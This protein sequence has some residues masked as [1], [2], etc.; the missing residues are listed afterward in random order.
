MPMNI[1]SF[2][3]RRVWLTRALAC[4]GGTA[5]LPRPSSAAV[6]DSSSLSGSNMPYAAFDALPAESIDLDGARL[7]VAFGPGTFEIS[8]ERIVEYVRR[9]AR[10]VV[11]YFGR[12]PARE[13]RLLILNTVSP[14]RPVRSGTAFGYGGAAIKLTLAAGVR[15]EDLDRDWVLVHEMSHLAL[16]SLPRRHHWFEEGVAS[17]VEPLARAQAGMLGTEQVWGDMVKGMPQGLP[18]A[19]D[20]GLDHTPTWGRTYWGGAL[21]CLLADVEMRK[22]TAGRKGL[23]H[24]L[25]AILEHGNIERDSSL[26]PLLHIGDRAVGVPVLAGLYERMKDRPCPVDLDALWHN[27]GVRLGA[28]DLQFDDRA[29][30]SFVRLALT[31]PFASTG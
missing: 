25:R 23:Q 16:P 24:A 18:Q 14:G 22:A 7:R 9:S 3:G 26:E 17:Y 31:L 2:P 13:T 6:D 4:L 28:Q 1:A 21:F 15:A 10:S 29:P 30:L 8:R 19:G 5:L 12:F 27:L 20:Q 11:A